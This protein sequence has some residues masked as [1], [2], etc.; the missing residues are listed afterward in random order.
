MPELPD[1]EVFRRHLDATSLDREVSRAE[2][3]A[4]GELL[5]DVSASTFRRH[6]QGHAF[7]RTHRHGKFLLSSLDSGEWVAFHFG[8]TGF[9]RALGPE[10]PEPDH[11][12]LAFHFEDGG[13]LVYACQRKLGRVGLAEAPE[14]L[15]RERGLGP[16]ALALDGPAFLERLEGRTGRVKPTLMNQSVMAGVGNVYSDEALFQT[17]LHP[18]RSVDELAEERRLDL[19]GTLHAVLET[20]IDIEVTGFPD[21]WLLPHREEGAP[22]PRCG[23]EVRRLRVS[24]RSAYVCPRCQPA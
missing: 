22:C 13:R 23:G 6:L 17:G 19:Q 10:D 18:E 7:R 1:V 20:A 16:D 24:G 2:V 11:V 14:E 3:R 4:G 12:R 8:M 21:D 9:L 15:A 5:D